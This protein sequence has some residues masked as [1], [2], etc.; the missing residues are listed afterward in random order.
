[1]QIFHKPE[2]YSKLLL[3]NMSHKDEAAKHKQT[4]FITENSP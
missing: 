4:R 1:M 2:I 3:L